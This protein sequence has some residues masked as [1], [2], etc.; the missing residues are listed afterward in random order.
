VLTVGVAMT[1]R[2]AS[3]A[4]TKPSYCAVS[5]AVDDYRG[6]RTAT[7]RALLSRALRLA[8][9]EIAPTIRT[10]RAVPEPSPKFDAAKAVWSRYNTDNCCTC[11]GGPNAPHL[12]VSPEP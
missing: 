5:R 6:H 10:M 1:P 11:L 7:V 12:L 8:P 3:G 2:D 9:R 4:A